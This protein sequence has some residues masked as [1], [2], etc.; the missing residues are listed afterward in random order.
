MPNPTELL[1]RTGIAA[2]TFTRNGVS[3]RRIYTQDLNGG[4]RET[5][6]DGQSWS[7]GT[8]DDIIVK[9]KPGTAIAALHLNYKDAIHVFY[10]T[11]ENIIQEIRQDKGGEWFDTNF[12][13]NAFKA[14][15]VS[16]LAIIGY[17][18]YIHNMSLYYQQ[19]DGAIGEIRYDS[20]K[21]VQSA[22]FGN[23]PLIGTGLAA[24]TFQSTTDEGPYTGIRVYYQLSDG[25]VTDAKADSRDKRWINQ[26][27]LKLT[28]APSN[29]NLSVVA[30]GDPGFQLFFLNKR[31]WISHGSYY[32]GAWHFENH[33]GHTMVSPRSGIAVIVDS[34]IIRFYVQDRSD[35]I[36][37]YSRPDS[38]WVKDGIVPTGN[39]Q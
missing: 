12:N 26:G 25:T 1:P 27:D 6:F 8:S 4:I 11:N 38:E 19:V 23:K 5:R 16:R 15:P 30:T 17:T 7:G 32:G 10:L 21:W 13:E 18:W 33:P 24:V 28:N 14:S 35:E 2:I 3:Q 34:D 37:E 29:G 39:V 20:G 9:A 36:V 31:N 22:T